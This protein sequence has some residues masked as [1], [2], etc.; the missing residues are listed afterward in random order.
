MRILILLCVFLSSFTTLTHASSLTPSST[1]QNKVDTMLV[2]FY[3]KL[4]K[5]TQDNNKKIKK[6]QTIV[7]KI[8]N[9]KSGKLWSRLKNNNKRL[10]LVLEL[11]LNNRIKYYQDLNIDKSPIH[12][13]NSITPVAPIESF[14]RF[15]AIKLLFEVYWIQP[16]SSCKGTFVDVNSVECGYFEKFQE[17]HYWM[18]FSGNRVMPQQVILEGELGNFCIDSEEVNQILFWNISREQRPVNTVTYSYAKNVFVE[19]CKPVYD[20][21]LISQEQDR[22][23]QEFF[24]NNTNDFVNNYGTWSNYQIKDLKISYD[25]YNK[26]SWDK[27]EGVEWYEIIIKDL[28]NP[29]NSDKIIVNKNQNYYI[30]TDNYTWWYP[31]DY[32]GSNLE[33]TI[34]WYIWSHYT[35]SYTDVPYKE[36]SKGNINIDY[37][38]Y[39]ANLQDSADCSTIVKWVEY[40]LEPCIIDVDFISWNWDAQFVVKIIPTDLS[41]SFWYSARLFTW[42]PLY[43]LSWM[44]GWAQWITEVNFTLR[45]KYFKKWLQ[46]EWVQEIYVSDSWEEK[47]LKLWFKINVK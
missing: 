19:I 15:D 11:K 18:F 9:I 39:K 28:T 45:D 47:S 16:N 21:F 1:I 8:E 25:W 31:S 44:S 12:I 3:Q 37:F 34:I 46:Y 33:I 10:L 27:T 2:W 24:K 29:S 7:K 22:Y 43:S 26:I 32:I 20:K 13:N 35:F 38:Y 5:S 23:E 40:R 14:T 41:K 42:L 6:L 4:D 36:L 17:I 30:F